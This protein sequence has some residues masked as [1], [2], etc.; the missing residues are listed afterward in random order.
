MF[1]R[2]HST[3]NKKHKIVHV[4]VPG[5]CRCTRRTVQIRKTRHT[6]RHVTS[7]PPPAPPAL[8]GS[9]PTH[10]TYGKICPHNREIILE[11][12]ASPRT[13][14]TLEINGDAPQHCSD[15]RARRCTGHA[16]TSRGWREKRPRARR[17]CCQG[18]HHPVRWM[19][20]FLLHRATR[21]R[22]KAVQLSVQKVITLII[23]S[24][25]GV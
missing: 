7:S 20:C 15:M 14:T 10:T 8:T 22:T 9:R 5:V 23:P 13:P 2:T 16:R 3:C 6:P 12:V 24:G 21:G 19:R 17:D 25:G 1:V 18:L 11:Y 4:R